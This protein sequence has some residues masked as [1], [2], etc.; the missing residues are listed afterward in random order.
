L[1]R[2]SVRFVV[3]SELSLDLVRVLTRTRNRKAMDPD[4]K[5]Y[6]AP[7]ELRLGNL[8][9]YSA[10]EDQPKKVVVVAVGIK[11]R[12]KRFIGGREVGP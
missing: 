9:V 5:L 10:V 4:K 7:W 1:R 6:L 3:G 2:S 12:Q 8:R 11:E